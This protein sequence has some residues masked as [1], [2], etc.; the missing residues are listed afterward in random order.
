MLRREAKLSTAASSS[1]DC[2]ECA[3]HA[4][5]TAV[6]YAPYMNK[7]LLAVLTALVLTSACGHSSGT[8]TQSTSGGA[9]QPAAATDSL[10]GV[11]YR[12]PVYSS[13]I[14][15]PAERG[16]APG[17]YQ[18]QTSDSVSTVLAW[19]KSHIPS[20]L[21][22][23]WDS[24]QDDGPIDDRDWGYDHAH[25]AGGAFSVGINHT[26]SGEPGYA[27]GTKTVVQVVD[28]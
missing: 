5:R 24:S 12:V 22:G 9:S 4:R 8:G 23:V 11:K 2:N 17:I 16:L 1:N 26:R 7:Q 13:N 14:T 3:A 21:G 19:Y 18:Y 27:P 6:R 10:Q 28:R 25:P 20:G 15:R